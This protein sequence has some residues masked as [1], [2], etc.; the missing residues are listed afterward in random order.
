MNWKGHGRKWLWPDWST[1]LVLAWRD[2]GKPW[3]TS[4]RTAKSLS[5]C[6]IQVKSFTAWASINIIKQL[7]FVRSNRANF[8][9]LWRRYLSFK[10]YLDVF[11]ELI[12]NIFIQYLFSLKL[13]TATN[14]MSPVTM[15]QFQLKKWQLWAIINGNL[16]LIFCSIKCA[17]QYLQGNFH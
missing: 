3:K 5:I 16:L 15:I 13:F 10:Y 8:R 12:Q 14:K 6:W 17:P 11:I 9:S 4:V 1:M 7:V 2:S